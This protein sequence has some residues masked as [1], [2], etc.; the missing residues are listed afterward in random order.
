MWTKGELDYRVNPNQYIS[1]YS[2]HLN[3]NLLANSALVVF[4]IS[5]SSILSGFEGNKT[6]SG[7]LAIYLLVMG[8]AV[9]TPAKSPAH[10]NVRSSKPISPTADCGAAVVFEIG[11]CGDNSVAGG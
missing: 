3:A 8:S 10:A 6:V 4:G 9:L 2:G 5:Q 1:R 7:P 11:R